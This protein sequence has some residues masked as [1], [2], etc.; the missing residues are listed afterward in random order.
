[1][2]VSTVS[3]PRPAPDGP[4]QGP[5]DEKLKTFFKIN[6]HKGTFLER[7]VRG[8]N[9]SLQKSTNVGYFARLSKL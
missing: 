2:L 1:M 6:R 3:R 8:Q 7:E 4:D 5:V 9:E